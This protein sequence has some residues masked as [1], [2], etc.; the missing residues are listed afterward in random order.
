MAI[1][2]FPAIVMQGYE[3]GETS[4]VL[5]IFCGAFGRLS[6]MAKGLRNPKNRLRGVLQ[7][8]AS[9]EL[10][11]YLKETSEMGTLKEAAPLQSRDALRGDLE[12]LALGALLVEI[13][14]ACCEIH[15][16]S[17]QMFD[18]VQAGLD[19]LEAESQA[20][21]TPALHHLLRALSIAGYEPNIDPALLRPWDEGA[22][23]HV[24]WLDIA[25][26]RIHTTRPQPRTIC[27]PRIT[28]M[29]DLEFPLP[30]EAVRA[31]YE[32]QRTELEDLSK[33]P[34]LETSHAI[35]LIEGLVR[36]MQWHLDHPIRSARFWRSMAKL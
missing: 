22:K 2:R 29:Q 36:L 20:P 18:V 19:A 33:L 32:N 28:N 30:P 4:E 25:E 13:A 5:H 8:L 21:A 17:A 1:E 34:A 26:G 14:S 24:F 10:T 7:P 27:W 6:I 16:E 23:P 15:Q 12:R 3:T 11:V 31:L 35:Q 9:V